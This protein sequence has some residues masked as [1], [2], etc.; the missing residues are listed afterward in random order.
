MKRLGA[1]TADELFGDSTS[2]EETEDLQK[3]SIYRKSEEV[4]LGPNYRSLVTDKVEKVKVE[5]NDKLV[6]KGLI[7]IEKKNFK[8]IEI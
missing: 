4:L 1:K 6:L 7:E 8:G 5:N 2:E 3:G